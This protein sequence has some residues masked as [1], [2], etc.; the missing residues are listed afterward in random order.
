[1]SE[2]EWIAV[3]WGTSRMRLWALDSR[4]SV[5]DS[6]SSD[7]GMAKL[8]RDEFEP[9]LIDLI[10]PWVSDAT[11]PVPVIACGMVGARQGWQEMPYEAVPCRPSIKF[12]RVETQSRKIDVRICWGL[13]QLDPADVMR[14][15]ETQIAGLL[16]SYADYAG[17]VCLP[18]THCKWARLDQGA[19]TE[20]QSYMTGEI[21]YLLSN[22]SVLRFSIDQ[23]DWSDDQFDAAVHEA[24]NTPEKIT[25]RL[26]GLRAQSLVNDSPVGGNGA[27]LSGYLIGL[28]LA[29]TR[30]Y[31]ES[32]EVSIIGASA[33]AGHYHRALS[34]VGK[35]AQ[36]LDTQQ[37]T[38]AGLTAAYNAYK[39]QNNV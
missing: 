26:F 35:T 32:N 4:G 29:S 24:L 1:M 10:E 5:I 36:L 21:F 18:G 3:D 38:L 9:T 14:G 33:L 17:V 25:G 19:V 23:H 15:E 12:S 8:A 11:H 37:M 20:F 22:N 16:G 13:K 31:W 2:L 6:Q 27:R 30:S 34:L 39:D 7:T 28:E